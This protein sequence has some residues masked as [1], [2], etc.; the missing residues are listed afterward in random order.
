MA[1]C[2]MQG[3]NPHTYLTDV[4]QRV[5]T[6]PNSRVEELTPRR[7]KELFADNPMGSDIDGWAPT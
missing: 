3:I 2:R 5:G 6:H 7:W 1:T 4:L